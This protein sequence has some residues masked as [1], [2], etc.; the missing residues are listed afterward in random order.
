[1]TNKKNDHEKQL[2]ELKPHN[3]KELAALYGVDP[4]TMRT[5]LKPHEAAIGEKM[6]NYYSV[7]QVK[8]ILLKLGVPSTVE[9]NDKLFD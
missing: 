5:W 6:G 7:L 1:M 4:R 8:T 3:L 9:I 2:I